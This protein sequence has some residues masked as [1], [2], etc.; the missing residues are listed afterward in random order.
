MFDERKSFVSGQISIRLRNS[1]R[2]RLK[3]FRIESNVIILISP[4]EERKEEFR[5]LN[6]IG[7]AIIFIL[8]WFTQEKKKYERDVHAKRMDGKV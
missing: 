2:Y 1:F 8:A 3:F 6:E 5:I 7:I 4:G